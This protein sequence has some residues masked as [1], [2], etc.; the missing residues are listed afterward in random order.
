MYIQTRTDQLA[1]LK[2]E[3]T[4]KSR[5]GKNYIY[6]RAKP[7]ITYAW[8][9]Y[10]TSKYFNKNHTHNL[11]MVLKEPQIDGDKASTLCTNTSPFERAEWRTVGNQAW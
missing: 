4:S 5:T 2:N 6:E 1:H 11:R 9:W 10:N 3:R 7:G 8:K